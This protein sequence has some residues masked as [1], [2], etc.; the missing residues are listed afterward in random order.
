MSTYVCIT[1]RN[2]AQ[3]IGPLVQHLIEDGLM[4]IVVDAA[5]TDGTPREAELAG[6]IVYPSSDRIPIGVGLRLAW[7]AA[8]GHD[9]TTIVQMDAG[10]SHLVTD[11]R[12]LWW[13]LHQASHVDMV[14]GSRFCS[15]AKYA[16]GSLW[17]QLSSRL[18]ARMCNAAQNYENP[19]TDWTSG[20]RAFRPA[21]IKKLLERNYSAGMHGWQ[22]E[23]VA[24]ARRL[25]LT[26]R[27][28]PITYIAGRSSLDLKVAREAY[29][30]WQSLHMFEA[31]S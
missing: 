28:A 12:R 1:T 31:R 27:E 8:L 19:L 17:R 23:V 29:R 14:I 9:A 26:I 7:E 16:G 20:F 25:G 4:P 6:A 21:A 2:E 22:I 10:G 5:S 18:A 24:E 3:T 30:V 15:G 13:T 11:I